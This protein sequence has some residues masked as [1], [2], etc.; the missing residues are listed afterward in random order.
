M[1]MSPPYQVIISPK[2]WGKQSISKEYLPDCRYKI[3]IAQP[4]LINAKGNLFSFQTFTGFDYF[5]ELW[6]FSLKRQGNV[7]INISQS[8]IALV[9]CLKVGN[10]PFSQEVATL[11][12]KNYSLCYYPKGNYQVLLPKGETILIMIAPPLNNL[13]CIAVEHL[14]VRKMFNS[15]LYG[16][17]E[18]IF[19][20]ELPLPHKILKIVMLLQE[21][22][23]QA[24]SLDLAIRGYIIQLLSL[25]NKQLRTATEIGDNPILPRQRKIEQIIRYIHDNLLD[26]KLNETIKIAQAFKLSLTTMRQEFKQLTGKA[27]QHYIRDERLTYARKVLEQ[28]GLPIFEVANLIQYSSTSNFIRAYKKM[29]GH[30]PGDEK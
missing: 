13:H 17:L 12:E 9:V 5:L 21:S 22:R 18:K 16:D 14:S 23:E 1:L 27:I 11:K 30:A 2:I 24:A 6:S 25:Y 4:L 20:R 10:R 7:S 26:E 19:L 15:L 8:F 28:S 3:S 29:F